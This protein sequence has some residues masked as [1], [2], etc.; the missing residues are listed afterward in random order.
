MLAARAGAADG[1]PDRWA[2]AA[3]G[4]GAST[5]PERR[6]GRALGSPLSLLATNAAHLDAAW[7]AVHAVMG[8]V[9]LAMSRFRED[10]ELTRCN[11]RSPGSVAEV[12]RTLTRALAQADRAMRITDG[13]FDPR[14][15]A[16][17]EAVGYVGAAQTAPGP[18]IP[19]SE[20]AAGRVLQR[21]SRNG[22]I[23][24]PV[25]V[26]LGGI[27]KG[28]A[29][30]WA[31]DAVVRGGFDVVAAGT[32]F[33][34]DAGGDIVTVGVPGV[35]ER[36]RIGIED[37]RG[38]AEPLAVLELSGRAAVATSSIR[39]LHW[40]HEGGAVH[41]LIDPRTGEPGGAGLLAVTVAGPD[42][43]WAEVW[44]KALFLEGAVGIAHAARRRGL[45]AWWATED[46]R[47]EMTPTARV[48]TI[49]VAGEA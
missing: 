12:S 33:L 26:D 13:L 30:R 45:A 36:W 39:R 43:A 31:A 40:D 27:G 17:L 1:A 15:V 44:S 16:A 8:E 4:S 14:V 25:P 9:D 32:G 10:S 29:L 28:L 49:W 34:I 41:H 42:P 7:D 47:I 5:E 22:P 24:L 23:S 3:A 18:S 37:P 35:G 11:R 46:G 38:E 20:S 19:A 21:E 48:R 6:S 2:S